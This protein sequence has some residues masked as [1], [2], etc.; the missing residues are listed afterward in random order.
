MKKIYISF[1]I[2]FVVLAAIFTICKNLTS[3]VINTTLIAVGEGSNIQIDKGA[4]EAE[5]KKKKRAQTKIAGAGGMA[6][7][8]LMR[9]SKEKTIA[10]PVTKLAKNAE[11]QKFKKNLFVLDW[12]ILGPFTKLNEGE[13]F[14]SAKALSYEFIRD[15]AKLSISTPLPEGLAWQTAT[16]ISL[17][18][19]VA[20]SDLF[21]KVKGKA[22]FYA[23]AEVEF[24]QDY[25]DAILWI[26]GRDDVKVWY[27]GKEIFAFNPKTPRRVDA[28]QIKMNLT[29]GKHTILVKNSFNSWQSYFYIRFTDSGKVPVIPVQGKKS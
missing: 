9:V 17:D 5:K 27:D 7:A 20:P 21:T 10:P 11:K 13:A 29:K 23:I 24:D 2:V 26:G 1:L 3:G 6:A 18:G 28:A 4:L 15:E 22:A 16:G 8:A 25:P 19:K 14:T 12:A